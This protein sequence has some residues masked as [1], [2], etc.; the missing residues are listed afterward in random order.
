M[1]SIK[2]KDE[3]EARHFPFNFAARCAAVGGR[4]QTPPISFGR[5]VDRRAV[6]YDNVRPH[7]C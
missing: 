5:S 4:S 7:K 3:G 6:P 1:I 2:K